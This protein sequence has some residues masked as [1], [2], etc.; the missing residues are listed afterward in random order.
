MS[1]RPI[2]ASALRPDHLLGAWYCEIEEG[3]GCMALLHR[4]GDGR[5][6]L[7]VRMGM[8]SIAAPAEL[9]KEFDSQPWMGSVLEKMDE[10]AATEST[11]LAQRK[12]M[13]L[14]KST[15][16]WEILRGARSGEEFLELLG[17][18]PGAHLIKSLKKDS[19]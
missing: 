15:K 6:W 4:D 14:A 9:I 2:D 17:T 12:M 5:T 16:G 8:S 13:Q 1:A 10:F 7:A 11:R 3:L 19:P 18:M